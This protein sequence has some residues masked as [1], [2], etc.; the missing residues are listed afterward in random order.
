MVYLRSSFVSMERTLL[1][2]RRRSRPIWFPTNN[3]KGNFSTPTGVRDKLKIWLEFTPGDITIRSHGTTS[4]QALYQP[5]LATFSPF[6]N[7]LSHKNGGPQ[8]DDGNDIPLVLTQLRQSQISIVKEM[9][10]A[11]EW[12][13]SEQFF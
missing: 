2:S 5:P 4:Y 13:I 10:S 6:F 9:Y 8:R 12:G 7:F 1:F 3:S 11:W